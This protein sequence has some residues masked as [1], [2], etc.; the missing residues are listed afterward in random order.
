MGNQEFWLAAA[1]WRGR[2]PVWLRGE[3]QSFIEIA[4]EKSPFRA[5]PGSWCNRLISKIDLRSCTEVP[6]RPI[7]Q[8]ATTA[9]AASLVYTMLIGSRTR[10]TR[11][12]VG[13]L[14]LLILIIFALYAA[15]ARVTN[16][17]LFVL[18]M[19][20]VLT[21]LRRILDHRARA[22]WAVFLTKDAA[23][24]RVTESG[25]EYDEFFR[26]HS[27]NWSQIRY[28]EH[29]ADSGTIKIYL[30]GKS[31]PVQFGRSKK[32]DAGASTVSQLLKNQIQR[33]GGDFVECPP[34]PTFTL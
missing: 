23:Y 12:L 13:L 29:F 10:F 26:S 33:S 8:P 2:I 11:R 24:G 32:E 22:I 28:I 9:G 14:A 19:I 4:V 20:L 18:V 27:A 30:F 21:P 17:A 25:I 6:C 3:N 31:R 15:L 34:E 7:L 5:E 1:A 16:D